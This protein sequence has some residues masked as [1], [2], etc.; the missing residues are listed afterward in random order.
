MDKTFIKDLKVN[1]ILG[2][3]DWERVTP[4]EIVINV[5]VYTDTRRAARTDDIADC[6]DYSALAI[7]IR[8]H[9]ESAA[10]MTVEALAND[11]AEL[12]LDEPKVQKVVVR[13]D[14]PGAV[15]EAESVGVEVERA[16]PAKV[17]PE[18]S[19]RVGKE[20]GKIRRRGANPKKV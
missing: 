2:I 6:V 4:R 5:T 15:A 19:R 9:A 20:A 1:G 11:L 14:K 10:R 16:Q 13:V 8:A 12:C 3:H 7:K 18:R 17:H